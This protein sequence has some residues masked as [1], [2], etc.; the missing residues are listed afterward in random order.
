MTAFVCGPPA[1]VGVSLFDDIAADGRN[2]LDCRDRGTRRMRHGRPLAV[3]K[4]VR[5][6]KR[7]PRLAFPAWSRGRQPPECN[8]AGSTL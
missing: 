1:I 6:V 3:I 4:L 2:A 5:R 7:R 8:R